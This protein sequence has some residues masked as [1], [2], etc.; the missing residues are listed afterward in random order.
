MQDQLHVK[1]ASAVKASWCWIARNNA[2]I[3]NVTE[4]GENNI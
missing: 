4:E 1:G 3:T 2:L